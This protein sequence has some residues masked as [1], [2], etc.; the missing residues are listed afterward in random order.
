L[1]SSAVRA[2]PNCADCCAL[3]TDVSL[4]WIVDADI[5]G[6][7]TVTFGPK[8][9]VPGGGGGV[10]PPPPPS[11]NDCAAEPLQVYCC[12]CTLSAVD[13]FGTSRHF[14]LLRL[15][16]WSRPLPSSTGSHCW[17]LPPP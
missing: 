17:L 3:K 2:V 6:S 8:S 1:N 5:D 10:V 16:K 11:E 7:K 9:G 12:N 4:L 13:A 14:P 15:T